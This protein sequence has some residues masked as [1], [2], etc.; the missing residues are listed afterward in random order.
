MEEGKKIKET[1]DKIIF[2]RAICT[3]IAL[4]LPKDL[5][6]LIVR[7]S[8]SPDSFKSLTSTLTTIK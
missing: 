6:A 7:F 5:P 1:K 4:T 2:E 3:P 8:V